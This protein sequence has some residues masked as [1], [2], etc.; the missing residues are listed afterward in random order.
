[1]VAGADVVTGTS[2]TD[3]G[4]TPGTTYHYVVRAVDAAGNVGPDSNAIDVQTLTQDPALFTDT[5]SN[6]DGAS[7]GSAWTTGTSG[8]TVDTQGGAGR[9]FFTDLS[10]AYARAQLTGLTPTADAEVLLSY[11]WGQTTQQSWANLYLRGTG[12]WQNA[13]RPRT[14]YGLELSSTSGAVSLRKNV[15][16]TVTTLQSVAGAQSVT[17][18]KQW[19]RFG[20]SGSTIRFKIWTDGQTEPTA[21]EAT[22][23][24]ASVPDPGQLFVSAV[25][26][27]TNTG[28]KSFT[29]DDLT[30]R[31]D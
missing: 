23:T 5:W 29:I 22:V 30:V 19:L 20:I 11:Q 15:N 28:T 1:V 3:T 31:A 27:G 4:L 25:R 13:Y 21:W 7:W 24:D 26:G 8:G 9:L 17:T 12:G 14:G 16:G 2:Y 10:G 18:A 6:P